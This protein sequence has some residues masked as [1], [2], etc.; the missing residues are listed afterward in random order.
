MNM[1]SQTKPSKLIGS[2]VIFSLLLI[3]VGGCGGG[4]TADSLVADANGT[5][6]QRLA[7][8][9]LAFQSRNDYEGPADEAAFKE[10]ISGFNAKKLDRMGITDTDAI[11]TS[12][13]DNEP[14]KVRYGV[15]GSSRGSDEAVIFETTGVE[16]KR[17]VAFL[18]TKVE[19]FE[20][21]QYDE[22]WAKNSE[23]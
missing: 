17:R 6:I 7:N 11:F 20:A 12:E 23:E 10:F 8:L 2:F 18:N 14:F 15:A 21:S 19:E 1:K 5:N 13:R 4:A 9:Y 3:G 22:L 16:G